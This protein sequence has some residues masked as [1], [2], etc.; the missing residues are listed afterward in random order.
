M[1]RLCGY[2][3]AVVFEVWAG[4][5]GE[6]AVDAALLAA[7]L[8]DGCDAGEALDALGC[9]EARAVIAEA[10]EQAR[11]EVGALPRS[12]SVDGRRD[13]DRVELAGAQ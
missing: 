6:P 3:I 5:L 13:V 12:G 4:A 2:G 1:V 9:G 11:A 7:P 8:G 10:G